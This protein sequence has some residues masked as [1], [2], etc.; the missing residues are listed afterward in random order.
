MGFYQQPS[1]SLSRRSVVTRTVSLRGRAVAVSSVADWTTD[2]C[3]G[4]QRDCYVTQ[5]GGW[6]S[7]SLALFVCVCL[8][9]PKAKPLVWV[10]LKESQS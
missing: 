4:R 2:G 3:M 1:W 6:S 5:V 8:S 9:S 10:D 7:F